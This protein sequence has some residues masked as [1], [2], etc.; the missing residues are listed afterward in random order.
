MASSA[1]AADPG[2]RLDAA[3]REPAAAA[4]AKPGLVFAFRSSSGRCRRA[5]GFLA[6]VL[7][8]RSNHETFRIYRVDA[9]AQP[10]LT[11]RLQLDTFPA[12]LVVEGKRV[13]ARLDEPRGC[14]EIESFLA[15]WLH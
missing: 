6:Q 13:R 9:D 1:A 7:Q 8:R 11:E 14:R 15:P 4:A 3:R 12:L 2:D 5:E 10:E